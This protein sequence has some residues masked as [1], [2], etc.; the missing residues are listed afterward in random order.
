MARTAR[1]DVYNKEEV[2]TYHCSSRVVRRAFLCGYDEYSQ[3]DYNHRKHWIDDLLRFM[4]C[5]FATDQIAQATLSNHLHNQLRN[6]PDIARKDSSANKLRDL[7]LPHPALSPLFLLRRARRG[8]RESV[9]Y[10]RTSPKL[11]DDA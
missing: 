4:A 11:R 8:Y 3:A 10:L 6:P 1:K 5:Y 7:F 2:G 9:T